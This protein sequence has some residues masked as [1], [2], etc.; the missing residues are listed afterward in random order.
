MKRAKLWCGRI[1]ALSV[2]TEAKPGE[3]IVIS[4][5]GGLGQLGIEYAKVTR[6]CGS[7]RG[8]NS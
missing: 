4:G 5:V 1:A 2:S 7:F 6:P 8:S 3:W